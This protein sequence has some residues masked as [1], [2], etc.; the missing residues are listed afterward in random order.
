MWTP[1]CLLSLPAW[2]A[3]AAAKSLQSCPTL[4][5]S[6]D[7]SPPGSPAPG[8]LQARTL[9]CVA[10][11]FS[12]AWSRWTQIETGRERCPW[13]MDHDSHKRD[14]NNGYMPPGSHKGGARCREAAASQP[15]SQDQDFGGRELGSSLGGWGRPRM[16]KRGRRRGCLDDQGCFHEHTSSVPSFHE[17]PSTPQIPLLPSPRVHPQNNTHRD[18]PGGPVVKNPPCEA[19]DIGSIP[20]PGRSSMPWGSQARVRTTEA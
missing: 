1:C 19:G 11:S 4:C 5:D 12:N 17:P 20:V 2:S 16:V 13:G 18:F 9:E 14:A 15:A 6:K 8:I 10:I 3:A 7:G